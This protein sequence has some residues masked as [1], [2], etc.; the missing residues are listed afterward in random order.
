MD[1]AVTLLLV[2]VVGFYL[3]TSARKRARVKDAAG[4]PK[5]QEKSMKYGKWIGGGLGW[6]LGG[7]IGAILGFAFGSVYDGMQSGKYAHDPGKTGRGDFNVSLLVLSAAVMKAD[8]KVT[9]SE[10]DYVKAFL[11]KQFGSEN[12]HQLLLMLREI[13]KQ[14]YKL[15]DVSRQIGQYM[16]YPARLQLL[17][18]LFGLSSAD[19]HIHPGELAMISEISIHLGIR[20][21]DLNSIRAMFVKDI[22]HAYQVLEISPDADEEEIKKAYRRMAVKYHPDKVAH[23]GED[24]KKAATEKFQMVQAA[25]EEIKKQKGMK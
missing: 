12:G 17:H 20:K 4:S 11:N 24:V 13:L 2:A 1:L 23:L 15:A 16:D 19:G 21:P 7:P 22:N 6:A 25:Y 5:E 9:R 14:D 18:Y 10:L 8:G 3:Y